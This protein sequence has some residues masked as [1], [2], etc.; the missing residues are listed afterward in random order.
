MINHSIIRTL[1]VV[2]LLLASTVSAAPPNLF[3]VLVADSLVVF[4]SDNG[5]HPEYTGNA[6]LRGSKWN[7]YEGGI[8][9]PF[10]ASWP[11]TIAAGVPNDQPVIGYDLLP[12]FVDFAGGSTAGERIDGVSL[13]QLMR[14]ES[15]RQPRRLLRHFLYYRPEIGYAKAKPTI[16]IND[17]CVSK[18]RPQSAMRDDDSKVL[19]FAEEHRVEAYDLTLDPGERTD[20]AKGDPQAF[21][22]FKQPL[23]KSLARCDAR[24]AQPKP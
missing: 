1:P 21:A 14:G 15:P 12:T 4:I 16:G 8:R 5:G 3:L 10:I 17:F 6:P 19:W 2:W 7:L 11:G 22:G 18:T 13:S 20:L 9:V 24:M 23:K